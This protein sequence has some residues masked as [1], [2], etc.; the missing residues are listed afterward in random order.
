MK[1]FAFILL[2]I[3][4]PMAR[5]MAQSPAA[6]PAQSA[7]PALQKAPPGLDNDSCMDCHSDNTLTG[8]GAH[9]K[10][11]SMFV[12]AAL[13]AG[14]AHQKLACFACHGDLTKKHPDDNAVAKPVDCRRCHEAEWKTYA[15]SVHGIALVAGDQSAPDCVACH[16]SHAIVT[17]T[18]PASSLHFSHL[19]QTCG[20]CHKQESR[21][22]Q[23]SVHGR[24]AASGVREA[25]TCV[26]C[27]NDHQV[28]ALKDAPSYKISIEICSRCHGSE[29][30]NEKFSMPDDRVS[31]FLGSYHGLAA[32]QGRVNGV[33][34]CAS[35]HGYHRILPSSDP[36]SSVNP[37][38]L[39]ETCG[40]CHPNATRNFAFSRVHSDEFT[41]SDLG[42][43]VNR[44]V[45][46]IYLALIF[47]VVGTLTL[48][49]M[50]AWLRSA[51]QARRRSGP[52]VLRMTRAFRIQHFIL[53]SSF[54]LLALTGFAL[55][56][57]D[58]WIAWEFAAN[59]NVRRWLHRG[60]GV[61][62]MGVG[63]FHII[64]S[65]ATRD[66]RRL[67]R[68]ILPR[69]QDMR[70]AA[71]NLR[72]F[73]GRT[74]TR[75]RYGRFGYAEKIE[76][77][78]VAWGIVIMGGTGLMIWFKMDATRWVPRWVVEAAVVVHYYEAILACLAIV[79]WH[80]YH[81]IF[82]P[83]IYPMNWAWWD[84][85]VSRHWQAEEHPL[86]KSTVAEMDPPATGDP[87]DPVH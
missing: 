27:H 62:L 70:D 31:T 65:L 4:A 26:D 24:A 22:V 46:R 19:A 6:L 2:L 9:G 33:A 12:D 11:V 54:I 50:L 76:Y 36:N 34:N 68:D 1:A 23:A 52:L 40:R 63:L 55:K 17:P 28:E 25:A 48:H 38:H 60:A 69:A 45:R 73:T 75:P 81:V 14:S 7:I 78:A 67:V 3:T 8:K 85:K 47:T 82:A 35:C 86:D 30:I 39:V 83:D 13:L 72:Y 20:V 44:W 41:G 84:G 29:R 42:A 74:N 66:G 71:A 64:Y 56:Y 79:V 80:F 51:I 15:A 18:S 53:L 43:I 61:V 5:V 57:P 58:S 49:N 37:K 87:P 32:M 10:E 21:D 59:E 16:G 77:W